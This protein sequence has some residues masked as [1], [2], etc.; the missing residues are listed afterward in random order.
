ME[1]IL[2]HNFSR[3]NKGIGV[4]VHFIGRDISDVKAIPFSA[5][6]CTWEV[7]LIT[8]KNRPFTTVMKCFLDFCYI[9]L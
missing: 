8:K 2:I 1:L 9:H 7:C 5:S 6:D 3:L 4:G